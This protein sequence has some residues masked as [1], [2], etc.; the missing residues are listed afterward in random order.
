MVAW[1][2]YYQFSAEDVE[3]IGITDNKSSEHPYSM[4]VYLKSGNR[5]S[6]SYADKASRI[7]AMHNLS[8]DIDRE[9]RRDAESIHNALY[10]L[11]DSVQ[12]IDKR[13]L[14]IWRQLRDL[15]GLKGEKLDD[16]EG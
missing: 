5:F 1:S 15:L 10:I 11:R 13:Q 6:L 14:R 16:V 4:T 2:D 12:R 3:A 8:R 7:A 9:K